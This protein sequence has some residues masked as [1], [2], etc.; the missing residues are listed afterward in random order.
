MF[1][2]V[3]GSFSRRK[4]IRKFG[5]KSMDSKLVILGAQWGDEGK[6]KIVDL[7]SENY[8]VTVRYQG[9]SNAGHT[10]IAN[11][12]KFILHLLPTGILHPHVAGVIA[13]GMVVDL[14]V[15]DQELESLRNRGISYEGRLLILPVSPQNRED[16][17]L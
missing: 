1:S 2:R 13:Q 4:S 15:L 8:E 5:V 12:E 7:L 10:V 9:G 17:T 14:D 11:G 16:H 6:G 3:R